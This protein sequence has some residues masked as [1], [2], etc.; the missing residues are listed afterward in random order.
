MQLWFLSLTTVLFL[1]HTDEVSSQ[2]HSFI[3]PFIYLGDP[4]TWC[5][6]LGWILIAPGLE[7]SVMSMVMKGWMTCQVN[8]LMVKLSHDKYLSQ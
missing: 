5:F 4:C 2:R 7:T 1:M 8:K 3:L 6:S